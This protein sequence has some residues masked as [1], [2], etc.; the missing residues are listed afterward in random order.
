MPLLEKVTPNERPISGAN[1]AD[2]NFLRTS[3][4]SEDLDVI[5]DDE[6]FQRVKSWHNQVEKHQMAL[7]I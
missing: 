1:S 5:I 6:C 3:I 2:S 4:T 7:L